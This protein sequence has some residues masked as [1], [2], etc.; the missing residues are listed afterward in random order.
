MTKITKEELLRLARI[1][2]LSFTDNELPQIMTQLESVLTYAQRVTE[3][4][5][6]APAVTFEQSN[7]FREDYVVPY[8]AESL[9]ERA[10]DCDENFFVVPR[11][12][13][14]TERE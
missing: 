9:L 3:I 1:S 11:I 7:V 2:G 10:P 13:S 12:L 14:N 5:G 6:D 4:A 8:N